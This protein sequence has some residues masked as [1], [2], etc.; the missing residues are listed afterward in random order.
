MGD[1]LTGG[2][3]LKCDWEEGN[4]G[5]ESTYN[6]DHEYDGAAAI[7]WEDPKPDELEFVQKE[8]IKEHIT[9]FES[10]LS[11]KQFQDSVLGYYPFVDLGS[12]IDFMICQEL[13]NNVDAYALSSFF[14]KQRDSNGGKLVAGP[15]WDFNLSFGN[16]DYGRS[17]F[18]TT[19]SFN[20][21]LD[22]AP[23]WWKRMLEDSK[24]TDQMTQRWISLRQDKLSNE[25][26][27]SI[28]DS[29][30]TLLEEAQHRNFEKW[31]ILGEYVW[32]NYFIGDTFEEEID[33]M[34]DWIN[35]RLTFLDED[36]PKLGDKYNVKNEL[37]YNAEQIVEGPNQLSFYPNPARSTVMLHISQSVTGPIIIDVYNIIGEKVGEIVNANLSSGTNEITWNLKNKYGSELATGIYFAVMKLNYEVVDIT[38]FIKME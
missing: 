2:Y 1:S 31:Q 29:L 7:I 33:F 22:P 30:S 11:S 27:F 8:Y 23:R 16:A 24:F 6:I 18:T 38:K 36:I 20:T 10:V 3:I 34:K 13:A 14:Y 12:F 26:I 17:Q 32:P 19:Y 4:S 15:L 5:W 9:N 37:D 25:R 21:Y 35:D 28:I